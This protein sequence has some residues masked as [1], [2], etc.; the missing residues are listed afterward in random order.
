MS[1]TPSVVT[2]DHENKD[3][4]RNESQLIDTKEEEKVNKSNEK[5]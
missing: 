1:F 2:K 5:Y 4:N 3:K